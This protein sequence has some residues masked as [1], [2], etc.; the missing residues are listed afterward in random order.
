MYKVMSSC[1]GKLTLS[2]SVREI[3]EKTTT[4]KLLTTVN[5]MSV[6]ENMWPVSYRPAWLAFLFTIN[7]WPTMEY[8]E[9]HRLKDGGGLGVL[10]PHGG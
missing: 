2:T 3:H 8:H 4:A 10:F 1:V 5:S 9:R 6:S 7:M